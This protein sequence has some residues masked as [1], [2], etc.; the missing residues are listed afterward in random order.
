MNS[1]TTITLNAAEY[2]FGR[3]ASKVAFL[4]QGKHRA[5]YAPNRIHAL[6]V[7]VRNIEQVRFTGTKLDSKLMHR[8]TGYPGGIK[9]ET[10]RQRHTRKPKVLFQEAVV[11]MLPKNRLAKDRLKQLVIA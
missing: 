1:S 10:L 6:K 9:T 3:L 11:R 2:S 5:D 8:H 4:L 7:I